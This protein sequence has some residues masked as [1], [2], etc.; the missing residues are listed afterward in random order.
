LPLEECN[1]KKLTKKNPW[2]TLSSKIV[3]KNPWWQVYEDTVIRPDGKPGK[4]YILDTYHTSVLVVALDEDN[5]VYLTEQFRYPTKMLSIEL[6]GGSSDGQAPIKAAKRELWEE[7]GLKASHWK[8][9][10][11]FQNMN[12]VS[13]EMTVV[14]IAKKLTYTGKDKAQE[15]GISSIQ[16]VPLKKVFNMIRAGVITDGQ[17]IAAFTQAKLYLKL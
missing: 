13:S 6:P 17:S 10:G 11:T 4:Y 14:F 16:K 9:V 5:A 3:H 12:G 7:T 8:Q 1:M 2:K 15:E